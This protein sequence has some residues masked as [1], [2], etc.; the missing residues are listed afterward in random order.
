VPSGTSLMLKLRPCTRRH[1]YT[2]CVFTA[3]LLLH[4]VLY[5][6][7]RIDWLQRLLLL[8]L[9]LQLQPK[10]C[11]VMCLSVLCKC[12]NYMCGLC[13]YH[14]CCCCCC[15]CVT[16]VLLLLLLLLTAAA[17]CRYYCCCYR[18]CPYS[19]SHTASTT[20]ADSSSC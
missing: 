7:L 4:Q 9:L 19:L 17:H 11:S 2:E 6:R 1:A 3:P 15:C 20:A 13:Y 14:C 8:L 10:C 5:S 16:H 18:C 12:S